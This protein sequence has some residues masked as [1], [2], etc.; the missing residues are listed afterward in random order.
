MKNKVHTLEKIWE[1]GAQDHFE[2][3]EFLDMCPCEMKDTLVEI[4]N[5]LIAKDSMHASLDYWIKQCDEDE[6][7]MMNNCFS[8]WCS[9]LQEHY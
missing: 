3:Q 7:E 9:H 1:V 5:D 8:T 4:Q 2:L 6:S